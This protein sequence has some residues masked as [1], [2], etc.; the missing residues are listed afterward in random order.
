MSMGDRTGAAVV[1][2]ASNVVSWLS[3]LLIPG[4]QAKANIKIL[5]KQKDLYDDIS[6]GQRA[7]V[8]ISISNYEACINNIL[9]LYKEAFPDVPGA[10]EYVPVDP[11]QER[12]NLIQCNTDSIPAGNQWAQCINRYHEQNDITRMIVMDPRYLV[13]SD[14]YSIQVQD[15]LRGRLPIGDLVEVTTDTAEA[16]C[17]QGRIGACGH[18]LARNLGISRMRAQ[19][20]GREEMRAEVGMHE[21]INP[22]S[23]KADIREMMETPVQR[24]SLALT[25][26][27]LIQNSLQNVLNQN[28]QKPPHRLGE[29]KAK[30]ERCVNRLQ[31]EMSKASLV[32]SFVPN[33]AAVIQPQLNAITSAFMKGPQGTLDDQNS[34]HEGGSPGASAGASAG[35][36]QGSVILND[37]P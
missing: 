29:L 22:N 3:Q 5:E 37:K 34:P 31:A 12:N 36:Q 6:N 33:Y 25:Q 30:M 20:S 11:C 9:P 13:K 7:D 4:L 2:S 26:A 27:Q 1:Y 24:M 8:D 18:L 35:A 10:A 17:F 16:A 14:L 15:L 32:N 19:K 23:R 21:V 28:A